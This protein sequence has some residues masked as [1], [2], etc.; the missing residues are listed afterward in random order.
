MKEGY[1]QTEIGVI[2]EDWKVSSL[3]CEYSLYAGGDLD[4]SDYSPVKTQEYR[5]PIYSNGMQQNGI[6]GFCACPQFSENAVTITGRGDIGHS[7]FRDEPFSAI[8]RLLVCQPK[9]PISSRFIAE[10]LEM[11]KPFVFESTGVPQLTVPQ[12]KNTPLPIPPLA[13]QNRI[14]EALSD[15]DELIASLEKLIEKKKAIK[16]GAMQELLTGK[17]R[18]PGFCG[19]WKPVELRQLGRF[20]GGGTPSTN[21]PDWWKG[22][23]PWISS[24]DLEVNQIKNIKMSRFITQ[25]AVIQSATCLCPEG[26]V[27]VVSRVGVGKVAVAPIALCTSQDFTNIIVEKCNSYFLAY[28]L[29][30][31]MKEKAATTQ[32]TSIK[33]ITSDEIAAITINIPTMKEQ[34]EISI[35][36][37]NFD[38]DIEL[39]ENKLLKAQ[40]I[41]Q[42]MMQQLLTGK[43]RLS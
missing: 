34:E 21:K 35:I 8:I 17:R 22:N 36:L 31:I 16:Q 23:I 24:S 20:V 13:E 38:R 33:G 9:H 19:L 15:M 43:I 40:Q 4:D 27:L 2:P 37:C 6:Y 5:F 18:L 14:A 12:I 32:G 3:D 26:T 30:A 7:S 10:Y 28:V 41:K 42:G 39:I 1:K 29:S 11:T 25:E